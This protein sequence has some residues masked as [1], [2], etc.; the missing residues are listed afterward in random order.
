M[1]SV[2]NTVCLNTLPEKGTS[3]SGLIRT[4]AGWA[5]QALHSVSI[6][7]LS[8][9]GVTLQQHKSRSWGNR[10]FGGKIKRVAG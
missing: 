6:A 10:D 2:S 9:V 8:L 7:H 3:R 1:L 5:Y 4:K